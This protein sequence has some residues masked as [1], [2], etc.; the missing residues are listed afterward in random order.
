MTT[1][2]AALIGVMAIAVS[3][4]FLAAQQKPTQP[5]DLADRSGFT[6]IFDGTLKNWDGDPTLWKAENGMLVGETT[7][8]TA[9][10]ENSFII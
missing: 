4:A 10:K 6:S 7:E 8:K 9:L 2:P 5:L 3:T 1:K